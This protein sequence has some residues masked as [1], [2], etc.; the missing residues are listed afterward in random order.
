MFCFTYILINLLN[1]HLIYPL[2]TKFV[3]QNKPRLLWGYLLVF[4]NRLLDW[5]EE[6]PQRLKVTSGRDAVKVNDLQS[7][8]LLKEIYD[9]IIIITIL[10]L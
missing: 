7:S 5:F 10:S 2:T 1:W 4:I 8:R 6:S 3:L 9:F